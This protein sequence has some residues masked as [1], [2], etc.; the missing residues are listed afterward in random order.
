[1]LFDLFVI[2][3][4]HCWIVK[5]GLGN[6]YMLVEIV[7]QKCLEG[8]SLVGIDV[9]IEGEAMHPRPIERKLL[10]ELDQVF[11]HKNGGASAWKTEISV[12]LSLYL[13]GDLPGGLI[14]QF[15]FSIGHHRYLFHKNLFHTKLPDPGWALAKCLLY[16]EHNDWGCLCRFPIDSQSND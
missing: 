12:R 16:Y 9:I 4:H 7:G 6:G 1:M 15:F 14:A 13:F 5:I 11:V 3:L 8:V 10:A 2:V